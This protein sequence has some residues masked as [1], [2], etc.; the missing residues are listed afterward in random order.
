MKRMPPTA[1]RQ[2]SALAGRAARAASR[3]RAEGRPAIAN[4][5]AAISAGPKPASPARIAGKD[6]AQAV[7][8]KVTV[9]SSVGSSREAGRAG[10][11]GLAGVIG[12]LREGMRDQ[13]GRLPQLIDKRPIR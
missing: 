2:M 11:A 6:E 8:V 1:K 10:K 5:S 4:R 9:K 7:T 3:N 13:L 12:D